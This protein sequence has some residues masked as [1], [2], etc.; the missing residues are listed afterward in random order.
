MCCDPICK[1]LS[2]LHSEVRP[3]LCLRHLEGNLCADIVAL[4]GKRKWCLAWK[5]KIAEVPGAYHYAGQLDELPDGRAV[6]RGEFRW[7]G[8][9]RGTFDYIME[10]MEAVPAN[11]NRCFALFVHA[12]QA[13][14][15]LTEPGPSAAHE[16]S[17]CS[18]HP[19]EKQAIL[20]PLDLAR[21]CQEASTWSTHCFSRHQK[22]AMISTRFPRRSSYGCHAVWTQKIQTSR[23]MFRAYS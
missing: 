18:V 13:G 20:K 8:R 6:L 7:L 12:W 16:E 22:Q 1:V 19:F 17:N 11:E 2:I 5:E 3:F 9:V 21:R 14:H 10:R 4:G 15:A 23:P